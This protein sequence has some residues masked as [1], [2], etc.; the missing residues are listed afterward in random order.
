MTLQPDAQSGFW[1]VE[2]ENEEMERLLTSHESFR[3]AARRY[4]RAH[5]ELK[6]KLTGLEVGTRYRIGRFV[7]TPQLINGGGFDIPG[8][9]A[10]AY[11]VRALD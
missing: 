11:D 5:R 2:I 9:E 4:A 10:Q 1:D 8:W 7:V 3:E 6:K